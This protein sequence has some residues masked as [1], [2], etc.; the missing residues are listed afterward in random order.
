[1]RH[2]AVAIL[3][4]FAALAVAT[5]VYRRVSSM[6]MA[7]STI[8]EPQQ[9]RRPGRRANT[10][11]SGGAAARDYS[12][13]SH[14]SHMP[15]RRALA[16]SS[17]HEIPTRGSVNVRGYPDVADYP[18]H[19]ACVRCHRQQFFTGARPSICTICHTRVSPRDDARFPFR[20]PESA[21]QFTIEFPHDKHQDVIAQDQLPGEADPGL[22]MLL[23]VMHA[24]FIPI[25]ARA[26]D[27]QP[28]QYNNCSICHETNQR[29]PRQRRGG[30]PDTFVPQ[31]ATFK[32]VPS[33]HASCFDCHW[34]NQEPTSKDCA[35]CHKAAPTPYVATDWP[36]RT[37]P[38]FTHAREQHVAECTVCHINITKASSLRGLTPDVPITSCKDCHLRSTDKDTVTIQKEMEQRKSDPNFVCAKCHTSEKGRLPAPPSHFALLKG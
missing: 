18:D 38:K 8:V 34:K 1:M 20:K 23:R 5:F 16:C 14:L 30:W 3:I 7:G 29:E 9:R 13:F 31:P 32:T 10:Q 26:T 28:Q 21:R 2:S 36:K 6:T 15:P 33:S 22:P 17:C 35:G 19:D 12:K 4:L 27:E 24:S 25:Y 37:S 11:R